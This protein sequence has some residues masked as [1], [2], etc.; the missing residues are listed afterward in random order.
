[1]D[2]SSNNF[3]RN[4]TFL[5]TLVLIIYIV[6]YSVLPSGFIPQA[7]PYFVLLF[8][9]SSLTLY[10]V[11]NKVKYKTTTAFQSAY[12][13]LTIGRFFI[14]LAIIITYLYFFRENSKAFI[15]NFFI[16]YII[17]FFFDIRVTLKQSGI[18]N[19]KKK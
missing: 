3:Y 5:T 8:P 4:I 14:Y 12:F 6:L 7:I 16:L 1:M 13:G 10:L 2:K 9:L 18:K 19:T 11:L 17:F 15:I